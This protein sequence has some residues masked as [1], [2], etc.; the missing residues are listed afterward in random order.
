[1]TVAVLFAR[2]DSIYKTIPGCDVWDIERDALNWPG[3]FPIVGHPPCRFWGQLRHLKV[4]KNNFSQKEKN[5]A[6]WCVGQIRK[7]GGVLEHPA[8]SDAWHTYGL[9]DPPPHG[10]WQRT[11]C[12]G[13]V[14]H[15]ALG[16]DFDGTPD[17]NTYPG[18]DYYEIAV[19]QFGQQILPPD[20][21]SVV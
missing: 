16:S 5:L 6:P 1:M 9:P 7:W 13:F 14:A 2:K 4:V 21:K 19:R 10:G 17:T 18:T 3:G 15:V 11:L 8:Y 20:R 12:G